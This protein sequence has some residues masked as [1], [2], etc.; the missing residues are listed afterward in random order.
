MFL[1]LGISGFLLL[2]FGVWSIPRVQKDDLIQFI[3]QNSKDIYQF[4]KHYKWTMIHHHIF[5]LGTNYISQ[6][7]V[8]VQK[9]RI[10]IHFPYGVH[11]YK[12]SFPRKRGPFQMRMITD[13]TDTDVSQDVLSYMGPCYNFYGIPT[14]PHDLGYSS[15]TFSDFIGNTKVFKENEQITFE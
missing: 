15:L 5:E 3:I 9:D 8:H 10:I 11:W 12:L 4:M 14:A 2:Y 1:Y 6:K 13:D 7:M